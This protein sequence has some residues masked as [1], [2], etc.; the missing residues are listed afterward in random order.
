M[1]SDV[2]FLVSLR[3]VQDELQLTSQQR[4]LLESLQADLAD[5]RRGM[6][7]GGPPGVRPGEEA[8]EEM[9]QRFQA[10]GQ[11]GEKLVMTVLEPAQAERLRQL[12]L[13]RLG[14]R[15]LDRDDVAKALELSEGQRQSIR[16]ML[17]GDSGPGNNPQED[18]PTRR[19]SDAQPKELD[20]QVMAVL[21]DEQKQQWETMKGKAF[22][23]PQRPPRFGPR[24]FRGR[25]GEGRRPGP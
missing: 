10:L 22:A 13:Q 17:S 2:T 1:S 20:A 24:G 12:R 25:G 11:Q 21:S 6:F 5:Q 14:V 15:A 16:G 18:N 9:R 7:R 19:E 23:F 8:Q 3:E 4:E